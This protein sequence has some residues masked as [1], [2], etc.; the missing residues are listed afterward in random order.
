MSKKKKSGQIDI[1]EWVNTH[2]SDFVIKVRDGKPYICR[3]P[4]RDPA[5][6]KSQGEQRQVNLF[7]LAVLYAKEV[8]S[9]PEKSRPYKMESEQAGRSIYHLAISDYLNK[10][11]QQAQTKELQCDDMVV[12]KVGSHTFL[13]INFTDQVVFKKMEV[14]LLELD[15]TL[16]ENGRAEA[17]TVSSWW[18]PVQNPDVTGLP[19]RARV[20]AEDDDGIIYE[21][22]RI[23]I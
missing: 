12:E 2:G 6:K 3:K 21:N 16:V 23:I 10:H 13:K 17:A 5:R 9:D 15:M 11:R 8:I 14:T 4:K 7:K 18:Y 22:E 1:R 19:F 20:K